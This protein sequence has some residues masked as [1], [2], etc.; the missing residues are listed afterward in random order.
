MPTIDL[1]EGR[2]AWMECGTGEPVLLLHSSAASGA[3]WRALAE[4]LACRFRCVA[5]DLYG[6]GDTDI[7]PGH[8]PLTLSDEAALA[9]RLLGEPD[10]PVHLVGHSYGGAVALRMAV[11]RPE[12]LRS[13]T[14][15]EP[16]AFHLLRPARGGGAAEPELFAEIARLAAGVSEAV[17]CGDYRGGMARFVDYWNGAGAWD[18]L[19]PEAQAALSRRAAKVVLD[20]W[21][22]MTEP[23][24]CEAYRRIAA[25]TLLL[26]GTESPRPTP[27]VAAMLAAT[28][29]DAR[30]ETIEGAGHM[31]PITHR[32]AVNAAVLNHLIGAADEMPR[33]AA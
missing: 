2:A 3:Q 28:I 24:W 26:C 25:P 27:H 9:E 6:Y 5:P 29:P 33:A 20:F 7:W 30:L 19:K 8:G 14:L 11:E 21:A 17:T 1:N 10:E 15:I 32:E 23:T 12:R 16:V 4:T 22:T 13:L 18:R 31:L